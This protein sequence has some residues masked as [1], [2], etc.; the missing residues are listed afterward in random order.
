[1]G[2]SL[3]DSSRTSSAT[4]LTVYSTGLPMFTGRV[5]SLLIRRKIPSTR[6]STYW[7]L[8]VWAPSPQIVSGRPRDYADVIAW[9]R[10]NE[11]TLLRTWRELRERA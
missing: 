11:E 7:T 3:P 6:S 2:F 8:R 9:A 1:M 10:D 4:S 5:S